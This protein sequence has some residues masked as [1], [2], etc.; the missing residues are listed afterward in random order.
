MAAEPDAIEELYRERYVGFRNALATVTGSHD[1]ARDAVQEG[2]ARALR[3][4]RSVRGGSLAAPL[5]G[6]PPRRRLGPARGAP[7]RIRES[8]R[9]L[10]L[11]CRPSAGRAAPS[12][13]DARVRSRCR[14]GERA[15]GDSRV[16]DREQAAP[17]RRRRPRPRTGEAEPRAD[18]RRCRRGDRLLRGA[19]PRAGRGVDRDEHR[20]IRRAAHAH[21]DRRAAPHHRHP[22]GLGR[23]RRRQHP[24]PIRG[25]RA[26]RTPARRGLRARADPALAFPAGAPAADRRRTDA[27][28]HEDVFRVR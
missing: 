17:I 19:E 8:D 3:H 12:A 4:R 27:A 16:R 23:S 25:R 21:A 9:R 18:G 20:P 5:R 26:T 13:A 6:L 2:F 10:R 7:R 1:T 11:A 15:R 14:R 22:R 24:A 28:G